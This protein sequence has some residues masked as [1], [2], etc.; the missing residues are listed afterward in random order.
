MPDSWNPACDEACRQNSGLLLDEDD[1]N[2]GISDGY[3]EQNG[4]DPLVDDA[5]LDKDADGHSNLKEFRAGTSA[6]DPDDF[7]NQGRMIFSILPL[8]LE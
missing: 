6:N 4:L 5:D 3:E 2:D 8:I 1:D 7:P